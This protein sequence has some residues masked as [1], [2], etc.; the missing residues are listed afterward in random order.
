MKNNAKAI[1]ALVAT[2]SVL[3][4]LGVCAS[5]SSTVAGPTITNEFYQFFVLDEM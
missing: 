5:A 2:L 4:L 1:V 3:L